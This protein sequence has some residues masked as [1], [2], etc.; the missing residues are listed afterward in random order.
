MEEAVSSCFVDGI[1]YRGNPLYGD[2]QKPTDTT[3]T[4]T[5]IN[6]PEECQR[7]C[8]EYPN[9]ECKFF[10]WNSDSA[11]NNQNTCWLKSA[12]GNDKN[13]NGVMSGPKFCPSSTS[14][15]FKY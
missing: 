12:H 3:P 1:A 10:T 8:Q 15:R 5:N 2:I 6:S 14:S 9:D 13:T 4:Y 11:R 7:K